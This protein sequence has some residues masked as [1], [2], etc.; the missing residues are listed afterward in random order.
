MCRI[1]AIPL[2][3]LAMC[4]SGCP[5]FNAALEQA[6]NNQNSNANSNVNSNT[7][8]NTNANNNDN[9]SVPV[10]EDFDGNWQL[11]LLGD[12]AGT[13]CLVIDGGA[14]TSW[15]EGC[16]NTFLQITA[17]APVS[18]AGDVAVWV[19]ETTDA[20]GGSLITLNTTVQ[21]DANLL[22]TIT[23]DDPRDDRFASNVIVVPPATP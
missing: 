23:I 22:G 12:R 11:T 9:S 3:A 21:A 15:N 10:N 5:T 2:A 7:N 1:R 16:V 18:S 19:L 14:I 6:L 4:I 17:S 20:T 13:A 8:S